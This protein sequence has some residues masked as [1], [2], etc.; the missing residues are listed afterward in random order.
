M[1]FQL[2]GTWAADAVQKEVRGQGELLMQAAVALLLHC[3]ALLLQQLSPSLD[4]P[5]VCQPA[6]TAAAAV[7]L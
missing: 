5:L 4:R 6:Q 3:L 7:A 2:C 1:P